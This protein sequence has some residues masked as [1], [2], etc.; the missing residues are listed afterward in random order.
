[1]QYDEMILRFMTEARLILGL[2]AVSAKD[3]EVTL[4]DV[5]TRAMYDTFRYSMCYHRRVNKL[6]EDSS[7]EQ[8]EKV[9]DEVLQVE[10]NLFQII[11]ETDEG[12]FRYRYELKQCQDKN[13]DFIQRVI[14]RTEV[15]EKIA[16][17]KKRDIFNQI[18]DADRIMK[19]LGGETY[20]A[21]TS[22]RKIILPD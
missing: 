12:G 7:V 13:G 6:D 8:Q 18:P 21:P 14:S 15:K 1:M 22:E 4:V 19:Q 2:D 11:E 17:P 3:N 5:Q 20:K 16:P 10:F 9:Y